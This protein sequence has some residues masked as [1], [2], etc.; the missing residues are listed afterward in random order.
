LRLAMNVLFV[1]NKM[2]NKSFAIK[3]IKYLFFVLIIQSCA[4]NSNVNTPLTNLDDAKAADQVVVDNT[5]ELTPTQKR[6][7]E[8][9]ANPRP[10]TLYSPYQPTKRINDGTISKE[11]QEQLIKQGEEMFAY[12]QR[13]SKD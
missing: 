8:I 7:Q 3:I 11:I 13:K 1:D 2:K 9:L 5:S 4:E 10:N 12:L 6:V